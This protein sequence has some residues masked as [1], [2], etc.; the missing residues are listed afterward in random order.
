MGATEPFV[1]TALAASELD[2]ACA[3]VAEAGWNQTVADWRIFLELGT[4]IA[5]RGADG[6]LAATAATLPYPSG[7][8]WISM[9][10]VGSAFRRR[11][12]ATRLLGRCIAQ[13]QAQGMVAVLDAT[14]AGRALY[15][16]LGFRD[17]WPIQRWRRAAP[18]PHAAAPVTTRYAHATA[19]R[20]TPAA[21]LSAAQWPA[22]LA[23]DAATFGCSRARLLDRLRQRSARFACSIQQ[24]ERLRGFL[25]GR[26]GRV[27]TQ[28]GPIVADDEDTACLLVA[29]ALARVATPIVVDALE[30]HERFA[31]WLAAQGFERERP[32]TRMALGRDP[33]FGDA[34]RT[35]AIAGPELG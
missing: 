3:L 14:P 12:L 13:L 16:P 10:L 27:A 22:V 29:Y 1:E 34:A 19:P 8:G 5:L 11:G 7:F 25:L 17:G 28:F 33:L 32:Y 18:H 2:A 23:L 6:R 9:V 31:A 4:A 30:R 24:G 26:D 15:L 20:A 35:L 21:P